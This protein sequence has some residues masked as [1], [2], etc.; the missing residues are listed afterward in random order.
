MTKEQGFSLIELLI[1]TAVIGIVS[2]IAVPSLIKARQYAQSGSAIQSLRTIVTAE[3]LYKQR[4]TTYATLAQ[5]APDGTLDPHLQVGQ[6]SG[7]NFVL[8]VQVGIDP[9][10]GKAG[11]FSCTAE[12]L[13]DPAN[14]SWYF[15]DDTAVIRW[16]AG[17]AADET[18]PAIP[19]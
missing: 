15:V 4:T 13:V 11:G 1:V 16:N 12:P 8:T 10:T 6:K 5:L 17:G 7:Y 3:S 19:R 9:I 14:A 2:A 18:S